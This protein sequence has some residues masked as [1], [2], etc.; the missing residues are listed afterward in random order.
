M[1][2][3]PMRD[4]LSAKSTTEA[5]AI[6][7]PMTDAALSHGIYKVRFSVDTEIN[8]MEIKPGLQYSNDGIT[9][10]TALKDNSILSYINSSGVQHF[11]NVLTCP[12]D[13]LSATERLFV[14]FG[15]WAYNTADSKPRIGRGRMMVDIVPIVSGTI[16]GKR[17]ATPS[18]GSTVGS[19][20]TPLTEGMS[21][22]RI[23]EVRCSWE[24]IANTG[25]AKTQPG[26]QTS[27]DG[28]TWDTA[29]AIGATTRTSEGLTY[30]TAWSALSVN[31]KRLIRF[32]IL[33][34]NDSGTDLE[35]CVSRLRVDWRA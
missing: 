32:G 21:A 24:M 30:G 19:L 1:P 2:T 20:F 34:S 11:A 22:P 28:V 26:Y 8:G 3:S 12:D 6:F 7:N 35:A 13:W 33:T 31:T 18:G 10:S 27:N 16:T 25:A 4:I 17:K 9:W 15:L 23:A 29:T 14:R 5:N